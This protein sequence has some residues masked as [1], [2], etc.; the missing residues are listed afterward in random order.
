MIAQFDLAAT[1]SGDTYRIWVQCPATPP[2]PHGFPVFVSTDANGCFATVAEAAA[3]RALADLRPAIIVGVGYPD[4]GIEEALVL[5][6]TELTPPGPLPPFLQA[7]PGRHSGGADAFRRFLV[8][9]L[10]PEIMRRWPAGTDQWT[11]FGHSLGGLF[12]LHTLVSE[13]DAF[14]VYVASSPSL[15][16]NDRY[17]FDRLVNLIARIATSPCAPRVLLTVGAREDRMEA[18][19]DYPE[20]ARAMGDAG[21]ASMAMIEN[22]DLFAQALGSALPRGSAA[23]RLIADEGHMG[24]LLPAIN[25][26]LS[27]ALGPRSLFFPP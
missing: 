13:P 21:F 18:P 14:A 17:L 27:F 2:P 10:R 24:V 3:L 19:E 22:A 16:F 12:V 1:A 4:V 5:R 8:D 25:K 26:A 6:N 9:D 23:F 20:D 7:A 11:I 15:W